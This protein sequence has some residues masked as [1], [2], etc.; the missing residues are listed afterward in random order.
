MMELLQAEWHRNGAYGEPYWAI[1]FRTDE[2]YG[3]IV[4]S[5]PKWDTSRELLAIV[6]DDINHVAVLGLEELPDV[7]EHANGYRGALY[8]SWLRDVIDEIRVDR[9]LEKISPWRTPHPGDQYLS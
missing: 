3:S 4:W 1:T 6:F 8:E 7:K 5:E 9:G 2:S